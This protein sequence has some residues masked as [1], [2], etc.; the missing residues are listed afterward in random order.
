MFLELKKLHISIP[1]I[2]NHKRD[3]GRRNNP[4]FNN[5]RHISMQVQLLFQHAIKLPQKLKK[6]QQQ[7]AANFCPF[8]YLLFLS[9]GWSSFFTTSALQPFHFNGV[10]CS[11]FYQ[12]FNI[13][14]EENEMIMISGTKKSDS[15]DWR[16]L[17]RRGMQLFEWDHTGQF[18]PPN[19][20]TYVPKFS[21]Y[22]HGLSSEV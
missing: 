20:S 11:I 7:A 18:F 13:N 21:N 3:L 2:W 14:T 17:R 16:D 15:K 5:N 22:L 19:T 4:P 1:T 6:Q 8:Y 9:Q 12:N 10:S